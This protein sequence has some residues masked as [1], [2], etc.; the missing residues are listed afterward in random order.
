MSEEYDKETMDL[1]YTNPTDEVKTKIKSLGGKIEDASDD[2]HTERVA[3]YYTKEKKEEYY[4]IL[5]K[6][7]I[8]HL[9]LTHLTSK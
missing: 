4:S 2:I 5:K 3:I 9:S 1:L 8:L 7:D 6:F